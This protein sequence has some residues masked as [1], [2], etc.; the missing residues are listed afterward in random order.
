MWWQYGVFGSVVLSACT[1][2][3]AVFAIPR[4]FA[5]DVPWRDLAYFPA[6]VAALGF[7]C[8]LA[9]WA[10]RPL[11]K[12]FGVFGDVVTGIVVIETLFLGCMLIFQPEMLF[13][14]PRDGL[15]MFGLG[16]GFGAFGGYITGRD[17]RKDLAA[18]VDESKNA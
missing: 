3:K 14:N 10:V 7:A 16:V 12:R 6:K 11:W 18:Q 13:E 15:L 5:E 4:F 8:G 1:L 9:V 2:V 17:L